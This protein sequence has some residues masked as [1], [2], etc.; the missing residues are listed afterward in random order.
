MT[1]TLTA[2]TSLAVAALVLK[3]FSA[4][5]GRTHVSRQS[6]NSCRRKGAAQS[7]R[8]IQTG[9][10]REVQH[11]I[12][13]HQPGWQ[14]WPSVSLRGMGTDRAEAGI[15]LDFQ[16]YEEKISG[17]GELLRANGRD[18]WPGQAPDSAV[19]AGSGA[20]QGRGSGD[21]QS[22]PSRGSQP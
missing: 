11:A 18:G 1:G 5:R 8:G 3:R 20:A 19:V 16:S 17:P 14:G 7:P 6:P 4:L 15:A 9:D 12:L 10:R 13:H 22:D 2:I 21:R